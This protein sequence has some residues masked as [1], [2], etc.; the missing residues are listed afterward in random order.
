MCEIYTKE[1]LNSVRS[2]GPFSDTFGTSVR[3]YLPSEE[4]VGCLLHC[5][6]AAEGWGCPTAAGGGLLQ[7]DPP[8]HSLAAL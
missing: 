1:K 3:W 7:A 2:H 6:P 8:V 5:G 4:H